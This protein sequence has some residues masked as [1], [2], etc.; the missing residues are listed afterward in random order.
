M[1]TFGLIISQLQ[2]NFNFTG[3]HLPH[4]P[5]LM[6]RSIPGRDVLQTLKS[7]A[8][9]AASV[10]ATDISPAIS[11]VQSVASAAQTAISPAIS[12][13]QS[14]ASAATVI[15]DTVKEIPRNCTLGTK[16][17][18]LGFNNRT[19]PECHNLPLNL[20]NIV[21]ETVATLVGDHVQALQPLP[22]ILT[23][24]TH[25]QDFLILG[26]VLMLVMPAILCFVNCL[27]RLSIHT[28]MVIIGLLICCVP[29][30]IPTVI[31]FH[32]QSKI[33]NLPSSIEVQKG[34][35][36]NYCLGVLFCGILM[37]LLATFSPK[38]V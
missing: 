24:V 37:T 9:S 7:E 36:S 13:I 6:P 29:F 26:L 4:N 10:V 3:I 8:Q 35:V 14:G 5:L 1:I 21:P 20:S 19:E 18:C 31:L 11:N 28:W 33:Q 15:P 22:G 25:I 30:F 23:I 32:V 34:D 38:L 17:F 16:Q 12:K 2:F 27:L